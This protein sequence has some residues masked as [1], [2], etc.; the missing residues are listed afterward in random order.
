MLLKSLKVP[1]LMVLFS[2]LSFSCKDDDDATIVTP[3]ND[4]TEQYASDIDS[5]EKYLKTNYM[6]LDSDLNAVITEIP[7]GG[8]QVSIWDQTDYPLN[9]ITVKNDTRLTIRTDG[10]IEDPVEYKLYYIFY[11]QKKRSIK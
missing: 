11:F 7:T 4:R 10:G 5:I 3:P 8:S 9:S 6:T 1:M 2:F